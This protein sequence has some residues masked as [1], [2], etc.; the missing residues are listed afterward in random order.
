MKVSEKTLARS[1]IEKILSGEVSKEGQLNAEKARISSKLGA[2]KILRNS[3]ILKYA[4][5]K[6]REKL[7]ILVK[8]PIRTLSGVA[9]VAVM[10]RPGE[11]PGKC[12]YCPQGE[13]APKSYTGK[14]PA[15]R[16]AKMFDYDPF[17]QVTKRVEQ[18]KAVGHS[19]DKIE[20]IVMGGTFLSYPKQEQAL[21]VKRCFDALNR[22]D[23]KTLI[24]AQKINETAKSRCVGLTI[25]TRPDFCKKEHID[26]M[27]LLGA[28]RVE[29]G[30]Q[31][32][33]DAIY[34]KIRRGH[35][36]K[37]V[38][39]ATRLMKD[40]GLKVVYHMMPG[41]LQSRKQDLAMF[42]KLFNDPDFRPDMLKIY[43]TLVVCG[44]GLYDLW[45]SGK[46][47]PL[48]NEEAAELVAEIKKN[49]PHYCRIMRVQRDIPRDQIAAGVTAGNLRELAR[50]KLK[51]IGEKCKCIRCREVGHT[52]FKQ[53]TFDGVVQFCEKYRAS[54][55]TEY[56]ISLEDKNRE[57]LYGYLRLRILARPFR[58]E[59]SGK[60]SVVRELKIFGT[61]VPI[62]EKQTGAI[63]H[64]GLGKRLMKFAEELSK[65]E[66]AHKIVVIAAVG[67]RDYYRALEYFDDGAYVSKKLI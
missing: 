17:V 23:S 24:E 34:K 25:E 22:I 47:K 57:V 11:C 29:L 28:T 63:Q 35:M 36:I 66:G 14:E 31:T 58:K 56:F 5:Q 18:L 8:K 43:P 46:Y 59:L 10:A 42:K 49:I 3:D 64:K 61:S 33:S 60:T 38:V 1:L 62:G 50:Q 19:I 9:I 6:E 51:A 65:K 37:D 16:R 26:T 55:G 39:E 52:D 20:L 2:S 27:L 54:E 15:A 30:V 45:K 67:T 13:N 53:N 4:T 48:E 21:F 41:L 32:L 7:A 40:S 44:T 12:I